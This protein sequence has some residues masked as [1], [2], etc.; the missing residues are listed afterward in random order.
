MTIGDLKRSAG[1]DR[2]TA[3]ELAALHDFAAAHGRYWKAALRDQWMKAS[4]P[5]ALHRLRNRLGPS[6]LMRFRLPKKA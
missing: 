6:W 1:I 4:A 5:P 2:L 3:D